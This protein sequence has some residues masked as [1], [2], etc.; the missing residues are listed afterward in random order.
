LAYEQASNYFILHP[1]PYTFDVSATQPKTTLPVSAALEAN[2]VTSIFFVG[3][4]NG[5][6][7]LQLITTQVPGLPKM[8]ATGS[9]PHA[10]STQMNSNPWAPWLFGVL[11]LLMGGVVVTIHRRMLTFPKYIR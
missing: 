1:G 6:P 4:F 10:T 3:M 8:P 7:Q 11:V 9:D 2:M 5:T